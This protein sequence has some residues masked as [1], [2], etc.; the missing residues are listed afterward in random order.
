VLLK[1]GWGKGNKK[2]QGGGNFL[3]MN[4][5]LMMAE[6]GGRV[7]LC[8]GRKGAKTGGGNMVDAVKAGDAFGLGGN[9]KK[10]LLVVFWNWNCIGVCWL[11]YCC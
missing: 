8:E 3:Q 11:L 9:E 10:L 2:T 1:E 7:T 6:I 4:N 5:V